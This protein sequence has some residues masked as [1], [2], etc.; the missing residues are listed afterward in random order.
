VATAL[1]ARP[2]ATKAEDVVN[3]IVTNVLSTDRKNGRK[4]MSSLDSQRVCGSLRL[5]RQKEREAQVLEPDESP[6]ATIQFACNEENE[7]RDQQPRAAIGFE[8]Q[9]MGGACRA[10]SGLDAVPSQSPWTNEV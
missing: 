4:F 10:K 7:R 8:S 3:F 6:H 2:R 1:P 5:P 9:A